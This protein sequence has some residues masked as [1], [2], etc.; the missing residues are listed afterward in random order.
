MEGSCFYL[1]ASCVL[2]THLFLM[3]RLAHEIQAE[4]MPGSTCSFFVGRWVKAFTVGTSKRQCGVV[5]RRQTGLI[6]FISRLN[7]K[8][9]RLA[10][11]KYHW[12]VEG[13]A[14]YINI[15]V[16]F[17]K[18]CSQPDLW[19]I[20]GQRIKRAKGAP[21]QSLG[22]NFVVKIKAKVYPLQDSPL[23]DFLFC[24][25]GTGKKTYYLKNAKL[26]AR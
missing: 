11:Y 10:K 18:K 1:D 14:R 21:F 12:G 19:Q 2:T 7:F 23:K 26:T 17:F 6:R 22:G 5:A 24:L 9:F 15:C 8:D 16:V 13:K 4:G 20:K 25:L 3:C